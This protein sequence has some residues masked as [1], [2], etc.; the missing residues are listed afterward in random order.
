MGDV[1]LTDA[2]GNIVYGVGLSDSENHD[3]PGDEFRITSPL[4]PGGEGVWATALDGNNQWSWSVRLHGDVGTP[5]QIPDGAYT[6]DF[7]VASASPEC[8]A[9]GVITGAYTVNTTMGAPQVVLWWD[10]IWD[11]ENSPRGPNPEDALISPG[12]AVRDRS[13]AVAMWRVPAFNDP[14]VDHF[15]EGPY[16]NVP[17]K[18][19]IAWYGSIPFDG[20]GNLDATY[21][22]PVEGVELCTGTVEKLTDAA[23]HLDWNSPVRTTCD[24]AWTTITGEVSA[25]AD[26]PLTG[27]PPDTWVTM[28]LGVGITKGPGQPGKYLL[29]AEPLDEA[30]RR[31]DS[32]KVITPYVPDGFIRFEVGGGMFLD[33]DWQVIT[34]EVILLDQRTVYLRADLN[35]TDENVTVTISLEEE[36]EDPIEHPLQLVR[37]GETSSGRGVYF[38][39]VDLEQSTIPAKKSR[40]NT[41]KTTSDIPVIQVQTRQGFFGWIRSLLEGNEL[42]A[43]DLEAYYL[44]ITHAEGLYRA[45]GSYLLGY[46]SSDEDGD[47]YEDGRVYDHWAYTPGD[48]A[49]GD[50]A[51]GFRFIDF[52]VQVKPVDKPVNAHLRVRWEAEDPDDQ[53]DEQPAVDV[54]EACLLDPGDCSENCDDPDGCGDDNLGN[55]LDGLFAKDWWELLP[56]PSA[57]WPLGDPD[58]SIALTIYEVSPPPGGNQP[59]QL[60]VTTIDDRQSRVRFNLSSAGGDNFIVT[61]S[62]VPDDDP[63]YPKNPVSTGV[64]TL[65]RKFLY[66]YRLMAN[67]SSPPLHT[68]DLI[69]HLNEQFKPA[70]VDF[71]FP[72]GLNTC[73]DFDFLEPE[74]MGYPGLI[75]YVSRWDGIGA[76]QFHHNG[77]EIWHF[78]GLGHRHDAKTCAHISRTQASAFTIENDNEIVLNTGDTFPTDSLKRCYLKLTDGGSWGRDIYFFIEENDGDSIT[79]SG[80]RFFEADLSGAAT[81]REEIGLEHPLLSLEDNHFEIGLWGKTEGVTYIPGKGAMIYLDTIVETGS[82]FALVV[83]HETTHHLFTADNC[84]NYAVDKTKCIMTY[85]SRPRLVYDENGTLVSFDWVTPVGTRWCAAHLIA[86][87]KATV[88]WPN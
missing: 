61:A 32:W 2:C 8:S 41:L 54:D 84:G 50:Y 60:G 9:G 86:M 56:I 46:L 58:P 67:A 87:R 68:D 10:W 45:D 5:D 80:I 48:P 4:Q 33:E 12:S 13:G 88:A 81:I 85:T 21:L 57:E 38:G 74:E 30:F 31:G 55:R 14:T 44:A 71:D 42:T 63:L 18:L 49:S 75:N 65:W 64:F 36:S 53:S 40:L 26:P 51:N 17:V 16:T 43:V 27:Y 77:E 69:D 11:A 72:E 24:T 22:E 6:I 47:S 20:D 19:Y 34:D 39:Q 79:V 28:G 23:G 15:F 25:S 35:E 62:L 76:G 7:E 3:Q 29:V 73:E 1:Y 78:L 59:T 66:E 82:D 52:R 70:F 37:V 83:D